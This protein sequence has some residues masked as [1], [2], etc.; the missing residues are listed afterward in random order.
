[1]H[2]DA[3]S[4]IQNNRKLMSGKRYRKPE[5]SMSAALV[6]PL[7]DQRHKYRM[8][9]VDGALRG[10][11]ARM[12]PEAFRA[13]K[14]ESPLDFAQIEGPTSEA[15]WYAP[16]HGNYRVPAVDLHM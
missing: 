1:M 10:K 13:P 16:S 11:S 9:K 14:E 4:A 8:S 7:L 6:S 3:I 15:P 5:W 2:E 12:P